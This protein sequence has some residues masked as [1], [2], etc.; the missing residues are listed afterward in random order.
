MAHA[1]AYDWVRDRVVL[2]GG[3]GALG[4]LADTWEWDGVT[5]IAMAPA[6]AP[7]ARD[8]HALAYDLGRNRTVLF[9]GLGAPLFLGDTWEWD[10]TDWVDRMPV[11][12]PSPRQGHGLAFDLIHART[13]LF[14]GQVGVQA[15]GVSAETW[16]WDGT[17]WNEIL[18]SQR[19]IARHGHAMVYARG[20]VLVYGGKTPVLVNHF[21]VWEFGAGSTQIGH[22]CPGSGGTPSL[23]SVSA[24]RIGGAFTTVLGDLAPGAAFAAIASGTSR[25]QWALGSL[26]ADLGPFGLP[27]CLLFVS[28][29][30]VRVLPVVGGSAT[31][32]VDVP[33]HPLLVGQP[34]HQQGLSFDPGINA[35]GAV[36]SNAIRAVV[37]D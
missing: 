7:P 4:R 2:F 37:G 28:P 16:A 6:H 30:V 22:G 11:R 10:G 18:P 33:V 36:V 32:T 23:A 8:G 24:L 26:P 29:D 3:A 19:P 1:M 15:N 34:F 14:G 5:W 20:K 12:S 31:L 25:T 21:D 9:G 13:L 27:G 35:A 17:V